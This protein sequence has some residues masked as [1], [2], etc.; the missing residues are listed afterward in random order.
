MENENNFYFYV[1]RCAD[2]TLYG[3]YTTDL[4]KRLAAHNSGNGAK[5]TKARRPVVMIHAESFATK[6]DAMS[7]EYAFKHQPRA[8]KLIYLATHTD[9]N[10]M[11]N[12]A[13]PDI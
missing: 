11:K 5:Y 9:L 8:K 1:L 4:T 12:E 10:L 6:H 7:A 3:G 13:H 2:D